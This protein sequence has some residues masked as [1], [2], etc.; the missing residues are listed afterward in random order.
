M[1]TVGLHPLRGWTIADTSTPHVHQRAGVRRSYQPASAGSGEPIDVFFLGGSTTWGA[2]QRDLHT[3]PSEFA[4]RAEDAGIPV[5]VTNYATPGYA[6]WQEIQLFQELLTA[7][8]VPD[9]VVFYDGINELFV[10]SMVGPTEDPTHYLRDEV[11]RAYQSYGPLTN[12]GLFVER[13]ATEYTDRS[14]VHRL[15][16]SVR[17]AIQGRGFTASY[18]PTIWAPG[19]DRVDLADDRARNA[20]EI[21]RRG[22]EVAQR[23]AASYGAR[24]AFF[25]QPSYYTKDRVPEEDEVRGNWAEDPDAWRVATRVA[26]QELR[27]PVID[28]GD[29]LDDVEEPVMYDFHHT[30]ERGARVVA[31]AIFG[32]L[33]PQLDEL[34]AGRR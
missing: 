34:G 18:A 2:Y 6:I 21:H 15:Y 23:L 14:V 9:L 5:R 1:E 28:L 25:W 17:N 20:V 22:L 27:S 12:R 31:D 11:L 16:R 26:R 4:R 29:V 33:R 32:L 8:R 19:A 13:A 24:T 30:N 10:Q 7:G 3:I